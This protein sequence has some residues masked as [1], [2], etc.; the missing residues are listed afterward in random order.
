ML[1]NILLVEDDSGDA[2]AIR[3]ALLDSHDGSFAV[4]WVRTCAEALERVR[5]TRRIAAVLLDLS[6]PDCQGIETFDRLFAV[7]PQRPILILTSEQDEDTA[8][9]AVQRGA[10]EYLLKAHLDAYLLP[11]AVGSMLERA[12]NAEAMFEQKERAQVTLNSIGDAVMSTNVAGQITYLNVVAERLTGWSKQDA[13][14]HP[15]A[16]VFHIVDGTTREVARDPMAFAIL[17]NHAV[18]LTPNC[19][20]LRKGGGEAAIEDSAAPIHDRRGVVTGAVMV[21]H[22][23]STTR[24]MALKLAYA[25]QHD[26]L[27]DLPNRLLFDDRLTEALRLAQRHHR[28]LAV[29]FL[30]IDRFKHIN[31]SVG[32]LIGDRLLQL[33]AQRV[34]GCVRTSDT[35][36]RQGGDEFVIL[37]P[38]V[39]HPEDAALCADKILRAI[40]APCL[41]DQHDLHV[42]ASIGIVTYPEDGN[43]CLTL[44]KY[45]DFA[46]YH[47]KDGGRDNRQFFKPDLNVRAIRRQ[48]LEK[49]LRYALEHQEFVLNYQPKFNLVTG[50]I[51]GVEALIRWSHPDWGMVPPAEFIPIAEECGLIAPIGR[52][53]LREACAQ[54]L[55]WR[56]MGLRPIRI[57][58]NSSAVELR[59]K[60]YVSEIGVVLTELGMDSRYLELELTETF[61]MQDA[62]STR[63]VLN[64][65][66]QIGVRLALDDF[67]T[68]Y[69]SL[70]HLRRFPID[71]LKIDRSF[72]RSV[73]T[74]Q[75]DASIVC[76]MISMGRSLHMQVV[77]EGVETEEQLAFLQEQDCPFGQGYYF[78]QPVTAKECGR[79]LQNGLQR[80]ALECLPAL[81]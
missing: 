67:G 55:A 2:L 56:A 47:A 46:M 38:E 42:T 41:I 13:I 23:V 3:A 17:E 73:T 6:L 26:S 79:L 60:G 7:I 15:L 44:M 32:H 71:T 22:D 34:Q 36:S 29:L 1:Q 33:I 61:L 45:A 54:A 58:I 12:A 62:V 74:E 51:A 57:G 5:S 53:V 28:R 66:K 14:G 65:L 25:A 64:D 37:L 80:A 68:V 40:R 75:E 10:Q 31:D 11:K 77:A 21:F 69:S 9:L 43:D 20:L 4:D 76:A 16:E 70:S 18:S 52:W 49:G 39:A 78:S 35:V 59:T 27:T 48:S 50:E 81:V 8:K 72:V 19:V 30:D 24:E 63:A